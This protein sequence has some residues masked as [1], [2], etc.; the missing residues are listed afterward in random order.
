MLAFPVI[1]LFYLL[2]TPEI[3]ETA[4][5]GTMAAVLFFFPVLFVTWSFWSRFRERPEVLWYYLGADAR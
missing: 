4:I 5:P 2:V 1:L 3:R